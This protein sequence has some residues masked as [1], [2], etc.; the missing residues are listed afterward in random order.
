M[1]AEASPNALPQLPIPVGNTFAG[2]YQ[3]LEHLASGETCHVCK[4]QDL[5]AGQLVALKLIQPKLLRERKLVERFKQEPLLARKLAHPNIV[6]IFDIGQ[7]DGLFFVSMEFIEGSD[8]RSL[9]AKGEAVGQSRF[10]SIFGQLCSALAYL[11]SQNIV[12]S[13]IQ[14]A[15]LMLDSQGTLK[16]IDFGIAREL[17]RDKRRTP[18][19][20]VS[21]YSAPE[22]LAG[23]APTP[24]ADI[25]AAGLVLFELLT[26]SPISARR[27]KELPPA[28]SEF[29]GIPIQ[30]IRLLQGFMEPSPERRF[31]R[32]EELLNSAAS[33]DLRVKLKTS[34]SG[35]TTLASFLQDDP[36]NAKAVLPVF[37]QLLD[38]VEQ[39]H[40]ENRSLDLSPKVIELTPGGKILIPSLP[41]PEWDRT[42]LIASPKHISP[43]TFLERT[44]EADTERQASEV[45]V[46]GFML[47]EILLGKRVFNLE[48]A[49]LQDPEHQYLWLSWHGNLDQQARPLREVIPGYS[50]SV[51]DVVQRMI[52]KRPEKRLRTFRLARE[53]LRG[54][55]GQLEQEAERKSGTTIMVPPAQEFE[56]SRRA[57]WAGLA[58][59][60][61]FLLAVPAL[62][63]LEKAALGQAL[64]ST[65]NSP[66]T[67]SRQ[68]GPETLCVE[69]KCLN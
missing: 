68:G 15:N 23:Q 39:A 32:M 41:E 26:G 12:H 48:F 30:L 18:I 63:F 59:L 29:S 34:E 21:E 52:E 56:K 3:I 58:A 40:G 9:I 54:L 28:R 61:M 1:T 53:A 14:P 24:A 42:L 69:P 27:S 13:D 4:A 67:E 8:L 11:H 17:A 64:C 50:E 57:R 38:A 19:R 16:L 25:F 2:R 51:S 49:E 45:Y 65:R 31:R 44:V 46:L 47:Y 6:R 43:E 20:G 10:L 35:K 37:L 7:G 22:V 55:L 60:A 33:L 66:R 62:F 5:L 36:P